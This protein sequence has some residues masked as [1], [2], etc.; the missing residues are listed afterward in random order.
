MGRLNAGGRRFRAIHRLGHLAQR[1]PQQG[2]RAFPGRE[3]RGRIG[4]AGGAIGV[5]AGGITAP[6]VVVAIAV[7]SCFAGMLLG[8]F[9]NACDSC[10]IRT[11]WRVPDRG[12]YYE[13]VGD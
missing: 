11:C 8:Y 5:L 3:F 7:G 4:G 2:N 1:C 6:L 13:A 9:Y 10:P 12:G